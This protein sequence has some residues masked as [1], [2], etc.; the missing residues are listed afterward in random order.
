MADG[1]AGKSSATITAAALVVRA[2]AAYLGLATKVICPGPASSMPATPVIS[3]SGEPF[4]S[5]APRV[6]A[7]FASFMGASFIVVSGGENRKGD[8]NSAGGDGGSESGEREI[9]GGLL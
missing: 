6:E 7:I 8:C 9:F 4:S 2:A 3:V 5:R 1:M